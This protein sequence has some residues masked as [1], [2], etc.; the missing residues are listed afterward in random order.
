MMMYMYIAMMEWVAS[1]F[2]IYALEGARGRFD[3]KKTTIYFFVTVLYYS[4]YIYFQLPEAASFF[5]YV[6]LFGYICWSYREAFLRSFS[7]LVIDLIIIGVLELLLAQGLYPICPAEFRNGI[8]EMLA[9]TL[10]ALSGFL[11]S[12]TKLSKLL[13]KMDKWEPSYALVAVL[14]LMIFAPV[15]LL[16]I[17]KK[18]DASE[19]IYIA[20]CILVMWLLVYKIQKYNLENRIRKKY[21]DSFT[22]IITQIRRRQ[23]KIK[24]QINSALGLYLFC[25]TYEELVEKQKEYLGRLWDY[26]LPADALILEEPLI[27]ALLYEKINESIERGIAVE[28]CFKCSMLNGNVSDIVWVQILGT[29]LDNAIE[30]VE[31][32]EGKKKIWIDIRGTDEERSHIAIRITN[33][34][35]P[36]DQEEIEKIFQ[37]GYSTKGTDRGIG[38]YDVK[39]LVYK[40]NGT[41]MAQMTEEEED[42]CFQIY[43][44][45]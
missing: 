35:E 29:V 28:T 7:M 30:A 5:N 32:Y 45:L 11:L 31:A 8:L 9:A 21:I 27:V 1:V 3:W 20:L 19:Y 18:L 16:R 13:H 40:Y 23:H 24:N 14:S 33:T 10:L 44:V 6:L 25:N 36:L 34:C 43:I 39:Q 41:L 17:L 26:E 42:D 37:M 22:D 38:L 2:V 12:R 15:I 4:S